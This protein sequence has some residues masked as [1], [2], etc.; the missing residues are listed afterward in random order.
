MFAL[1]PPGYTCPPELLTPHI[2]MSIAVEAKAS[3]N[4]VRGYLTAKHGTQHLRAQAI[5]QAI[6]RLGFQDPRLVTR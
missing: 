2:I 3:Y 1:P 5:S 6:Q 4:S